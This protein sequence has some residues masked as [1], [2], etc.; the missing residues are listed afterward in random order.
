MAGAAAMAS[1]A[2]VAGAWLE[3]DIHG[4]TAVLPRRLW[5]SWSGGGGRAELFPFPLLGWAWPA[6]GGGEALRA[7]WDAARAAAVAPALAAASWVCLALS[8]MLLADAV[9]LAA[10]SL[11]ARRRRPYRAPGPIASAGPAAEEEDDGDGDEEAG[12]TVGYPVVLVQIPMYNEREVRVLSLYYFGHTNA[13]Q[14]CCERWV[15][16]ITFFLGTK[17]YKLSI[18]AAC[19]M[20]W[21]SDRVIVQV[22]DDSTDP[23]V[24][25]KL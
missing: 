9:F 10:A 14:C 17:V 19:G 25:V 2:A 3:P 12:R 18:G 22:L 6:S 4:P 16:T 13:M 23:T 1:L 5:P 20:S 11:L 24:K 7:A 15:F 21:P 8:A